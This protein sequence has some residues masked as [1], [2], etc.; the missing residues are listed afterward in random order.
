LL[1][2]IPAFGESTD[3]IP[4]V[5]TTIT[6][7]DQE[8]PSLELDQF[9]YE[10]SKIASFIEKAAMPILNVIQ[11]YGYQAEIGIEKNSSLLTGVQVA[12]DRKFI[13]NPQPTGE[14][15][16]I[17]VR[18]QLE[19]S[20]QLGG[21]FVLK[22][23]VRYKKK[24]TLI[25]PA[26]SKKAAKD[27]QK[28]DVELAHHFDNFHHVLPNNYVYIQETYLQGKAK[29]AL[30][31][32]G[33]INIGISG[34]ARKIKLNRIIVKK[35]D[36]DEQYKLF[37]DQGKSF[38]TALEIYQKLGILKFKLFK[39]IHEKGSHKRH[40]YN[41]PNNDLGIRLI[42]KTLLGQIEDVKEL[43]LYQYIEN[44]F[45]RKSSKINIFTIFK[46]NRKMRT[47]TSKVY[48]INSDGNIEE[49]QTEY[50]VH[51]KKTH[52]INLFKKKE[53]DT[54]DIELT[55]IENQFTQVTDA[56]VKLTF[57]Q[58]DKKVSA[59]EFHNGYMHF[60][61][62]ITSEKDFLVVPSILPEALSGTKKLD[63]R[64]ELIYGKKYLN[65]LL[66]VTRDDFFN[67]FA[68]VL[69]VSEEDMDQFE[70][71]YKKSKRRFS[72]MSSHNQIQLRNINI[73][74]RSYSLN[75]TMKSAYRF[76]K[77]IEVARKKESSKEKYRNIVNALSKLSKRNGPS[78]SPLLIQTMH[79][80]I[81]SDD[82]F[83]SAMIYPQVGEEHTLTSDMVLYNEIGDK[84]KFVDKRQAIF[85]MEE[86]AQLYL[87][88]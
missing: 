53:K 52:G 13:E 44:K 80:L 50:S 78:F 21:G 4:P 61:N 76:L 5:I 3:D 84:S 47:D 34:S 35:S 15:D 36:Q 81:T 25:F 85:D 72:I 39:S 63:M 48:Q 49:F 10:Q 41:F 12:Y 62:N 57:E 56:F 24:L 11:D 75:K 37:I 20:F 60:I 69:N 67:E 26:A 14:H 32:G 23:S 8:L 45:K 43:D 30:N 51:Y 79:N 73:G 54:E 7:Q 87:N 71:D 22:G 33:P 27:I 59:N 29:L 6:N 65:Q 40:S 1:T 19:Y 2:H 18:D 55:I 38:K 82:F 42:N 16:K 77:Q 28:Y 9:D 31:Y 58:Q 68:E 66:Q 74:S 70:K 64:V 46:R 86:I 17:L 88:L 83:Y